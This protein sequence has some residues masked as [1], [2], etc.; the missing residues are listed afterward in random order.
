MRKFTLTY[1]GGNGDMDLDG[2]IDMVDYAQFASRWRDNGCGSDDCG[3]ADLTGDGNVLF[4]DL[5]EF[6]YNW[7]AGL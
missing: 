5:E 6:F 3:G 7:M 1:I 2:D 4:E